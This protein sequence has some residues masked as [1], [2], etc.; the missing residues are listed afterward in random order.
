[1]AQDLTATYEWLHRVSDELGV[2]PGAIAEATPHL[3]DLTRD[4]AHGETRPSA[5]LTAYL[6]G[7]AAGASTGA[8]AG[9]QELATHTRELVEKLQAKVAEEVAERGGKNADG[10]P[11][12]Q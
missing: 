2:D 8:A 12:E 9:G 5:P 4:V 11:V 7:V 1:M 6:V 10:D 3:L